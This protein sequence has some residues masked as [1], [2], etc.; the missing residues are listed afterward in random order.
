MAKAK[1]NPGRPSSDSRKDISRDT[2]CSAALLL[3]RQVPLQN[4]SIAAV[5]RDMNITPALIHYYVGQ[6][7]QLLSGVMNLFYQGLL[8]KM[9][10]KSGLWRDDL[11]SVCRHLYGQFVAFGG[12]AAYASSNSR[13]R[14]FQ[15]VDNDTP[16]YGVLLLESFT[17]RVR[18]AGLN[19]QRTGLYAHLLMELIINVAHSTAQHMFPKE[20]RKFLQQKTR[21]LSKK[22]FP[23]IHFA[24]QSPLNLDGQVAFDEALTLYLQG[25]ERELSFS[26]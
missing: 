6:R 13:F 22:D 21:E 24:I 25:I 16:D 26:D 4:L 1:N 20:H 14:V 15:L 11:V 5:A 9:P 19:R 7:D 23:N 10:V 12:I 8:Q 2:I 18:D 3:A 17:G